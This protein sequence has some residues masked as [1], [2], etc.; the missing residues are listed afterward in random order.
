[1]YDKRQYPD[2]Y[3]LYRPTI[4]KSTTGERTRAVSNATAS[5]QPCLYVSDR[6]ASG[7]GGMLKDGEGIAFEHGAELRIPQGVDVRADKR[8]ERPDKVIVTSA[9]GTTVSIPFTVVWVASEF[10]EYQKV[11]LQEAPA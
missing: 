4:A 8:G 3:D 5:D 9:G 11:Y 7:R 1:M 6:T 10:G 2:T